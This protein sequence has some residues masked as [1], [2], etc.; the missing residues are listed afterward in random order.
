MNSSG[1]FLNGSRAAAV[2]GLLPL[3]KGGQASGQ[4]RQ[5]AVGSFGAS[6]AE[7]H[8][9]EKQA[10]GASTAQ[11]GGNNQAR[12]FQHTASPSLPT[13]LT[14]RSLETQ[15]SQ[16][17]IRPSMMRCKTIDAVK[18][19]DLATGPLLGWME[20]GRQ[21]NRPLDAAVCVNLSQIQSQ[22]VQS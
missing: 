19:A 7:I 1:E 11:E 22:S 5:R 15:M 8:S 13:R 21:L 3:G 14:S 20:T 2:V 12:F 4:C 16:K 6:E 17:D 10:S 18:R 9:W